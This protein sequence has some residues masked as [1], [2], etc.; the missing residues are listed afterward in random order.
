[1][2]ADKKV[3]RTVQV[4]I[5]GGGADATSMFWCLKGQDFKQVAIYT[6]THDDHKV[7][8]AA[9]AKKAEEDKKKAADDK[10]AA[11]VK[12][13]ETDATKPDAPA[14]KKPEVVADAPKAEE[15]A[16]VTPKEEPAE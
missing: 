9:A 7:M 8:I 10:K 4:V 3:D 11:D 14:E 12:K 13:P 2:L 16:E 1:M 6:A 15:K 5:C